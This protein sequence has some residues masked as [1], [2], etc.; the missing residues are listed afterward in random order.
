MKIW[1]AI[2]PLPMERGGVSILRLPQI[3][4]V[5][6]AV[7]DDAV[8]FRSAPICASCREVRA[9]VI[10]VKFPAHGAIVVAVRK[11]QTFKLY[12]CA[13]PRGILRSPG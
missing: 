5:L 12:Y 9:A 10:D 4:N 1:Q 2:R 11:K 13:T 8:A 7:N 3:S 6:G